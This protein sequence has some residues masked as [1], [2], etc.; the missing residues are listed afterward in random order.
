MCLVRFSRFLCVHSVK[1]LKPMLAR[2]KVCACVC[3]RTADIKLD[4]G[5]DLLD[6][7]CHSKEEADSEDAEDDGEG[8]TQLYNYCAHQPLSSS[9][10]K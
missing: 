5:E 3:A 7:V 4:S 10:A 8:N 1:V 2:H 6:L 9:L